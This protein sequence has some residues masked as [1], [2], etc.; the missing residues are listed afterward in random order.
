M[1]KDPICGMPGRLERH[2]EAFCSESC[3]QEFERRRSAP[4]RRRLRLRDPLVWVPVSGVLLLAVGRAWPAAAGVSA[5]YADYLGMVLLP[6]IAGLAI[7]GLIDHFIPKTYVVRLLAG[8]RK[9]V[10]LRSVA[11]GFLAS[12]CSHGCLAIAIELYR[13]GASIPAVIGFLLASPWASMALTLILLSLF[14]LKG[15]VLPHHP[16]HHHH[17]QQRPI[18]SPR[19]R[20]GR[21]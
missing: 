20:V 14:G 8:P 3:I 5:V 2:G 19:V 17:V 6:A 15:I 10:I 9:R 11:L 13:K 21:V 18:S 16:K 4:G 7:G 12:T 1:R